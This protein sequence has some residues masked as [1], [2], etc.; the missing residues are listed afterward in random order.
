ME[1]DANI[2]DYQT[3]IRL[4]FLSGECEVV[5]VEAPNGFLVFAAE[6]AVRAPGFQLAE[7]VFNLCKI[8]RD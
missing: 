5:P 6:L 3:S 1:Q 4:S 2:M 8:H 7:A